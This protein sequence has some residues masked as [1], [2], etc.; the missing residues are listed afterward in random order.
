MAY[1]DFIVTPGIATPWLLGPVGTAWLKSMG[2]AMD[3]LVFKMDQAAQAHMPTRCDP[4]ALPLI[5]NDRLMPQ[6]INEPT[7]GYRVRLQQSL[8]LWKTLAGT[9]WGVERAVLNCIL[10]SQ[11]QIKHVTNTGAWDVYEA[12]ADVTQPPWHV[13]QPT[14]AP[15]WHWDDAGAPN[16]VDPTSPLQIPWWRFWLVLYATGVPWCASS[17][18]WGSSGKKWGDGTKSWGFSTPSAIFRN[19]QQAVGLWKSEHSWCRWIIVSFDDTLF[20]E[21]SPLT[22]TINPNGQWG[23]WSKIVNNSYVQ[24]RFTGARYLDCP[25]G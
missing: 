22:S 10:P 23:R 9:P 21:W 7:A 8:G 13:F 14:G 3:S 2:R 20:N 25:P 24:S 17:G 15:G 18:T 6:G 5:G 19:I 16:Y 11:P 1:E 4:T 12:G